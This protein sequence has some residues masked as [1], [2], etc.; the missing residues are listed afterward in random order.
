M[1]RSVLRLMLGFSF[2]GGISGVLAANA[3][4]S[5]GFTPVNKAYRV[6]PRE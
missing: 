3:V 6:E 5:G 1:T 4:A 2:W